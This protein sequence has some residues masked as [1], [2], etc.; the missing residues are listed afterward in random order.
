[1]KQYRIPLFIS[2]TVFMWFS[3]YTY[4]SVLPKYVS[5]NFHASGL[6]IGMI[7]AS[8]GVTQMLLR[9][10]VGILSDKWDKRKL[11]IS[12]G[13]LVTTISSI[14][15][16]FTNN[17]I[18]VLI[19]RG[20]AGVAAASWVDFTILYANYYQKNETTKAIGT[21]SFFN[22]T[23]QMMGMLIGSILV[24]M[25]FWKASFALGAI[26]GLIGFIAS[27]FIVEKPNENKQPMTFSSVVKVILNKQLLTVSIFAIISQLLTFATIFTFTI[28]YAESLNASDFQL[29][30]LA[31]MASLPTAI[32]SLIGG[33]FLGNIFGEKKVVIMGFI[34]MGL[35]TFTIPFTPSFNFL[36][37]VQVVAGSGRGLSFPVLMSLSIKDIDRKD[38]STAMGV[39]QAIYSIGMVIGPIFMGII[40]DNVALKV[41]YMIFGFISILTAILFLFIYQ[42]RNVNEI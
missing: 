10:P 7:T 42:T 15:L 30:L 38:R 39:F 21:L 32:A 36:L 11:F 5:E 17:L 25:L 41:G 26:I 37:I 34:L 16:F 18:I 31:V 12:L 22:N 20:L 33:R 14:G 24:Q 28:L 35:A 2:V 8:Y 3:L 40:A 29:G 13:L 9:I 6:M 19:C 23:S 1:M 27:F 4:V